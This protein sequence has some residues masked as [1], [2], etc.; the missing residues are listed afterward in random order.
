MFIVL[1]RFSTNKA[2]A[3]ALMDG[4]TLWLRRGFEEG[5]FVLAGS[6][7]PAGGGAILAQGLTREALESRLAE[8][9]FVAENVVSAEVHEVVPGPCD[10]RLSFLA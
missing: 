6:L 10:P 9:P 3:S 1:L 4:H 7:K 5:A 8:D 2:K